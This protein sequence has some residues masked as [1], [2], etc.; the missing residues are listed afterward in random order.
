MRQ[1]I[2]RVVD[3]NVH[4]VTNRGKLLLLVRDHSAI[5]GPDFVCG[6][7]FGVKPPSDDDTVAVNVVFVCFVA[8][9]FEGNG[10]FRGSGAYK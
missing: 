7:S 1:N 3:L 8:T 5:L 2:H 9:I 4:M 10:D 6:A